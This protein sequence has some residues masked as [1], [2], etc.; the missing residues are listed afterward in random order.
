MATSGGRYL[1]PV[2]TADVDVVVPRGPGVLRQAALLAILPQPLPE[3]APDVPRVP[4]VAGG[5]GHARG[6]QR[7]QR[8]QRQHRGDQREVEAGS[9]HHVESGAYGGGAGNTRVRVRPGVGGAPCT[10][11]DRS[12]SVGMSRDGSG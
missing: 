1:A 2:L 12:G 3:Q 10:A 9:M 8:D 7:N 6:D 5:R 11:R 4:L